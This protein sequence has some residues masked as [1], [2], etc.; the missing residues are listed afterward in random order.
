MVI[1][2]ILYG[3][4]LGLLSLF[5]GCKKT[6]RYYDLVPSEFPQGKESEDVSSLVK[7]NLR[8]AR[9]YNQ[10]TTEAIFDVL[11]YSDEVAQKYVDL[12]CDRRGKDAQARQKMV[13]QQRDVAQKELQYYVLADIR[14][15]QSQSLLCKD[16][17]WSMYLVS[18][19]GKKVEPLSVKEVELE[20]ELRQLFL[21]RFNRYKTAYLVK[22]PILDSSGNPLFKRYELPGMVLKSVKQ[23]R[24]LSWNESKKVVTGESG[25]QNHK[26]EVEIKDEDFY[27]G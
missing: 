13:Q 8:S 2:H 5:T 27:W 26:A 15:A 25:K 19:E 6:P 23:E 11:L 22:F 16:A 10:F 24:A 17:V 4:C 21:H 9:V 12:F 3:V 14:D 1:Y 18:M 7:R 20:P